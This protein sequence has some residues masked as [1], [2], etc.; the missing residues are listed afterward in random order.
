MAAP[1]GPAIVILERGDGLNDL[2][3][4]PPGPLE[5]PCR[6]SGVSSSREGTLPGDSTKTQA[7]FRTLVL[8]AV[9]FVLILQMFPSGRPPASLAADDWKFGDYTDFTPVTVRSVSSPSPLKL[10]RTAVQRPRVTPGESV[11]LIAEY[12][13]SAP[14]GTMTV[15]ETRIVYFN[16]QQLGKKERVISVPSGSK[17]SKLALPVPANAA[18][19]WY[20]VKTTVEPQPGVATRGALSPVAADTDR[21]GFNV[22][23]RVAPSAGAPPAQ[24]KLWADKTEYKVGETMRVAFEAHRDGYVTVVNVGTSGKIT[25]LYPNAFAPDHSVKG[26]RTYSV[27]ASGDPYELA[28]SGPAGVELVYAVFMTA[29][30]RFAETNFVKSAFTVVNESAEQFTRDIN[31]ALKTISLKEQANAALEITV[32]P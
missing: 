20:T 11:D 27:P 15:K 13:V 1:A 30:I 22:E 3:T 31:V 6:P 7:P 4:P 14:A 17:G 19:G 10:S 32:T 2:D 29:P 26:G 5:S 9:L 18:P 28:L 21:T 23:T 8:V 24:I 25:I 12:E 16:G